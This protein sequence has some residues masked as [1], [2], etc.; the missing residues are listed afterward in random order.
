MKKTIKQTFSLLL[1][2]LLLCGA[3]PLALSAGAAVT[4]HKQGD[5][6][7]FGSYPQTEVKD[8]DLI[9]ALNA[10][11]QNWISYGYYTGTESYSGDLIYAGDFNGQMTASDFMQYCDIT[12]GKQMYRGVQFTQYRPFMTQY[13]ASSDGSYSMQYRRGYRIDTIYWFLWEPLKWRVLEPNTGLVLC[14]TVIDSQPISN[15]GLNATKSGEF[16]DGTEYNWGDAAA[17]YYTNNY[18]RSSVRA[19]LT[20]ESDSSNFLNTAFTKEM[21]A[22]ITDT[23][24]DNSAYSASA[25]AYNSVSTTDKVFLLS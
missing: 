15:Y 14:E 13:S 20:D 23:T 1:V 3:A 5:V 18:A 10:E 7:E 9:A 8:P 17:T 11:A 2:I 22:K 19:W 16:S 6:I 24:I 21:H 12:Y 25:S 4:S